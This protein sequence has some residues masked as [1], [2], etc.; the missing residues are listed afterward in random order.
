[1]RRLDLDDLRPCPIGWN[2]VRSSD[3]FVDHIQ[4]YGMP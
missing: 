4:K 3:E 2:C 1:M